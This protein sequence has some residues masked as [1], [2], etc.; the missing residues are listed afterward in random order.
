MVHVGDRVGPVR[1]HLEG[2][3]GEAPA[4]RRARLDVPPR[5]DLDLDPPVALGQE[6]GDPV[7]EVRHRIL[8]AAAHAGLDLRLRPA[9]ELRERHPGGLGLEVP[10]RELEPGLGH[11]VP[12][13][14][15]RRRG[16]RL[17]LR[18]LPLE[19]HRD[20]EVLQN[21]PG[22][23]RRLRAVEGRGLRDH[24]AVPAQ[25]VRERRDDDERPAESS[26]RSSFRRSGRIPARGGRA[27]CGRSSSGRLP[28]RAPEVRSGPQARSLIP[29]FR[30]IC[31]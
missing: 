16:E 11:G 30:A 3:A 8:D 31:S 14:P 9:V 10:E 19:D 21:V 23:R 2:Q 20:E 27:R 1:V 4:D 15:L 13:E 7:E 6:R 5:L 29:F 12:A 24:F 26:G 22:R 25:P 17:G 18:E 28:F